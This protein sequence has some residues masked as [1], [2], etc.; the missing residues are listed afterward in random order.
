MGGGSYFY[1]LFVYWFNGN[2]DIRFSVAFRVVP[3][4][5][6]LEVKQDFAEQAST[7]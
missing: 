6:H 4:P 1:A 5:R 7:A 2:H 3:Q